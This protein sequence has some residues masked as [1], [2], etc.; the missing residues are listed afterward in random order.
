MKLSRC[1]VSSQTLGRQPGSLSRGRVLESKKQN[2]VG[3][4]SHRQEPMNGSWNLVEKGFYRSF[5]RAVPHRLMCS[6]TWSPDGGARG[7]VVNIYKAESN[8][9]R[10]RSLW[11]SNWPLPRLLSP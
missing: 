1:L 3:P 8:R 10:G 11:D 5:E 7:K 9:G 4:P 6:N 2:L